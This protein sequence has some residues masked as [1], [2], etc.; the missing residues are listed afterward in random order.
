[1]IPLEAI[2]NLVVRDLATESRRK[3][4]PRPVIVAIKTAKTQHER[5]QYLI[6][7]SPV[8]LFQHSLIWRQWSWCDADQRCSTGGSR[9]KSGSWS[10]FEWVRLRG[11]SSFFF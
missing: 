5:I 3:V 7:A 2:L 4:E 9:P 8:R 6:E 1:M 11:H 10:C